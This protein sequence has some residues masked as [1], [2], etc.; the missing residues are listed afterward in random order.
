MPLDASQVPRKACADGQCTNPISER[1]HLCSSR[2]S[3]RVRR[4]RTRSASLLDINV[5]GQVNDTLGAASTSGSNAG[6][7][8]RIRQCPATKRNPG[9]A[10]VD[11]AAGLHD[12]LRPSAAV[13]GDKRVTGG[14]IAS[15]GDACFI[16][17]QVGRDLGA[18]TGTTN[19]LNCVVC[20]AVDRGRRGRRLVLQAV[21]LVALVCRRLGGHR[22]VVDAQD[23]QRAAVAGDSCTIDENV[24]AA[25][26]DHH[27]AVGQVE[28]DLPRFQTVR[29][30]GR[31]GRAELLGNQGH[32]GVL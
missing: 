2:H 11:V 31:R 6:A 18:N 14:Q 12:G 27:P 8:R 19:S 22:H 32:G 1:L 10:V 24:G 30:L 25:D 3:Q 29:D 20:T 21:N 23:R 16:S 17:D 7:L 5:T 28:G 9:A 26:T 13:S 15:R 4:H